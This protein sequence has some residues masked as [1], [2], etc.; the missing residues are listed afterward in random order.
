MGWITCIVYE[1]LWDFKE[2]CCSSQ[3]KHKEEEVWLYW[4]GLKQLFT[5]DFCDQISACKALKRFL[6]IKN[7]MKKHQ[8]RVFQRR[9]FSFIFVTNLQSFFFF[10]T[11]KHYLPSSTT[12]TN[13]VSNWT[14]WSIKPTSSG[15][16]LHQTASGRMQF[17]HF[18]QFFHCEILYSTNFDKLFHP[19]VATVKSNSNDLSLKL[20]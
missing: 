4:L 19:T 10:S 15:P 11:N 5:V 16:R 7:I 12:K 20:I 1:R 6:W 18:L 8:H 3:L 14:E 2:S 13:K 9:L 17:V